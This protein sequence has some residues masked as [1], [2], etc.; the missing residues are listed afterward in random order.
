[1]VGGSIIAGLRGV[2]WQKAFK[3]EN[4]YRKKLSV[5]L[6]LRY[7]AASASMGFF[8]KHYLNQEQKELPYRG[9]GLKCYGRFDFGRLDTFEQI[10][11]IVVKE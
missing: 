11:E 6:K 2:I 7:F 9:F 3:I 8:S 1:L 4:R 10:P 5:F